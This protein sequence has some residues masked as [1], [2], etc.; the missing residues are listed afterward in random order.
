MSAASHH[1]LWPK[2]LCRPQLL[3]VQCQSGLLTP[4]AGAFETALTPRLSPC[5]AMALPPTT[6][7]WQASHCPWALCKCAEEFAKSKPSPLT[8]LEWPVREA[9][10]RP[11][12][13]S[14]STTTPSA[15]AVAT[16]LS[17]PGAASM[18]RMPPCM[19]RSGECWKVFGAQVRMLRGL[20]RGFCC[21]REGA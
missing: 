17:L 14:K 13:W 19:Q 16:R 10:M 18:E 7:V 3:T 21:P 6:G 2:Y 5:Q 20:L 1:A 8:F 11:A 9:L 4:R 12:L 15:P